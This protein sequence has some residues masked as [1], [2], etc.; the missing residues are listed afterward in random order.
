M[1][2]KSIPGI[3]EREINEVGS[4][5]ETR[6][7]IRHNAP[8]DVN[9]KRY[10]YIGSR[11]RVYIDDL[12]KE[13]FGGEFDPEAVII[14]K[15]GGGLHTLRDPI[16]KDAKWCYID[17][18]CPNP[19]YFNEIEDLFSIFDYEKAVKV[20]GAVRR[21][22]VWGRAF[23]IDR[24]GL[25]ELPTA[26]ECSVGYAKGD[27]ETNQ[28][29]IMVT[30]TITDTVRHFR[31]VEKVAD[32]LNVKPWRISTYMRKHN[33]SMNIGMHKLEHSNLKPK[34]MRQQGF[35]YKRNLH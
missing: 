10:L 7:K 25:R 1:Q 20:R 31:N 9:W 30:C 15:P 26:A 17:L 35:E 34:H 18:D 4:I 33:T 16:P 21:K 28:Q 13:L 8:M 11:G 24:M 32:V 12:I 14:H 5:R 27:N 19:I 3:T 6:E 2:W 23:W 29:P 22:H